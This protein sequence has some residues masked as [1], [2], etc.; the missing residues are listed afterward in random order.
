MVELLDATHWFE[1]TEAGVGG[2]VEVEPR[3]A[4]AHILAG[5]LAAPLEVDLVV[6]SREGV[7]A[8]LLGWQRCHGVD[9]HVLGRYWTRLHHH[10]KLSF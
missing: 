8:C 1:H 3:L 9:C 10:S 7:E 2:L 5:L 6:V 4:P